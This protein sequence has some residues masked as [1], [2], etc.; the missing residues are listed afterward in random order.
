MAHLVAFERRGP[1]WQRQPERE[2]RQQTPQRRLQGIDPARAA[3]PEAHAAPYRTR[4]AVAPGAIDRELPEQ[5]EEG[6]QWNAGERLIALGL[7]TDQKIAEID[8][9]QDRERDQK[10]DQQLLAAAGIFG[11]IAIDQR[12]GPEMAADVGEE[13]E[14]IEAEGD[15]FERGAALGQIEE[16]A[17]AAGKR[18]RHRRRYGHGR[19]PGGTCGGQLISFMVQLQRE[20]RWIKPQ[21]CRPLC[22][23]GPTGRI[24]TRC[25]PCLYR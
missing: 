13:P 17:A 11:G 5:I 15:E 9:H 1:P 16:F 10:S 25:N 4:Q 19:R 7:E 14:P 24:E 20:R 22:D 8:R 3:H 12:V 2:R 18:H 23:R 21:I 6:N